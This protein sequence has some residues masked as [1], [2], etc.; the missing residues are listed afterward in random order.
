M[1]DLAQLRYDPLSTA[2]ARSP[3]LGRLRILE[4]GRWHA[5]LGGRP[6]ARFIAV[7]GRSGVGKST[8][9]ANL[10]IAL[11]SLRSRVV[12]IDL[13][14]H[15]PTQHELFGI[16]TPVRG[17]MALLNEQI[18]TVEQALTP[19]V[20]RNLFLVS[21]A[22]AAASEQGANTEQQH[23]LLE[24]IWELD[25]DVVVADIGT[26]PGNDLVDLFA[27]GAL[28]VVVSGPDPRSIQCCYNLFKEQVVREIE[29]VAGGTAEGEFL[30]A[31]L[32]KPTPRPMAELLAHVGT[33]PNLRA[34]L[35]Q[36]LA[37]FGGRVVGNGV[38]GSD[39][40]DR[41]HATS[42]L[43]ADYLGITVP[44]LG[45]VEASA[46]LGTGRV[47]GRPLLS[48][49]GID[50]NVRRFHTMAEQLLMDDLETE[51][52]R[53]VAGPG[54]VAAR[55][56]SLPI[57]SGGAVAGAGV[58][59]ACGDADDAPLPAPL[60]AYMRRHPRHP[61]DWH[62]QFRSDSGR[63]I[64]VRVFEVSRTGA[65]IEAM[66][67]LDVGDQGR[68]IFSQI[69]GQPE[70]GVTV[71][72]ARRPLGRAGLRFDGADDVCERLT[73]LAHGASTNGAPNDGSDDASGTPSGSASG[74]PSGSVA[75]TAS[76]PIVAV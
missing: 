2:L 74:A 55:D 56:I 6:G 9:A 24:Q 10:A 73:A 32:A 62:A 61:V 59:P 20:V 11:A 70:V 16:A 21:A 17:L 45:I 43:I 44:V 25:A 1:E 54:P 3:S 27:L 40:A 26:D 33:K 39:E 30:I 60:G 35:E 66:P 22:G 8:I 12:L 67:G 52:P 65:S 15:R 34:A 38:R 49:A 37:A 36:A 63:D 57:A 29:H 4:A 47:P 13:D 41:I 58:T 64:P 50:R 75:A 46:Q 42:R 18:D 51:A 53:C 76:G 68:L 28:R 71:M 14:L 69:A 72:D 23:R 5:P 31:A 7:R 19:T 48:G